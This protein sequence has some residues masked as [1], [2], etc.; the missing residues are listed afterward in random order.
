MHK[1]KI[2]F[3]IFLIL[4]GNL[5]SQDFDLIW[6]DLILKEGKN[7]RIYDIEYLDSD[8]EYHYFI[9]MQSQ[10]KKIYPY[11]YK[12]NKNLELV[13]NKQIN[14]QYDEKTSL[15]FQGSAALNGDF[16]IFSS[17]FNSSKDMNYGFVSELSK[18]GVFSL[19]LKEID[20]MSQ[21]KKMNYGFYDVDM[22]EDKSKILFSRLNPYKK[23]E[24][25][26]YALKVMDENFEI[27]WENEVALPYK[28]KD[29]SIQDYNVDD[30]G[31]AYL[32]GK[33]YEGKNDSKTTKDD[34][35]YKIYMY[36]KD[37]LEPKEYNLDLKDKLPIDIV[38]KY[39]ATGLHCTG[40]YSD[41]ETRSASGVFH[42]D[43]NKETGGVSNLVTQDFPSSL[44]DEFR[45]DKQIKN[46][47]NTDQGLP[48]FEIREL[49]VNEKG[50]KFLIAEQYKFWTT[51]RSSTVN[52]VTTTTT[53]YHY[54]YGDVLVTKFSKSGEVEW[55][56][57]V[58]K[59]QHTTNDGG[60]YSS[61]LAKMH[62]EDSKI[63]I[64]FSEL[65]SRAEA[66]TKSKDERYTT[67]VITIDASGAKTEN[68][69]FNVADEE[70]IFRPKKSV[71]LNEKSSLIIGE[72][73]KD[74]KIG[75]LEY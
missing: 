32:Q 10:G 38:M 54:L 48:L 27:I 66:G 7:S 29:F 15:V 28:D 4:T 65:L 39:S 33:L 36:S 51:T 37:K 45:T 26:K 21:E 13:L 3:A 53:I 25:E 6:S 70:T 49:L 71:H 50:E 43:F 19:D 16:Y 22:S 72:R 41:Y 74:F 5:F 52:G 34:Y 20:A 44:R 58:D 24:Q 35:A 47:K 75:L 64:F 17:Y 68:N 9:F 23:D 63:D 67:K 1:T 61:F 8:E 14:F 42:L 46:D 2:L 62:G 12:F 11:L 31:N 57:H 56:S 69:L 73:K 59:Y 40:L 18:E 30:N 55:H 60:Y